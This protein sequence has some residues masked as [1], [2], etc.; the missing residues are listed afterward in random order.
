MPYSVVLTVSGGTVGEPGNPYDFD[1]SLGAIPAG[2]F[3]NEKDG[4]LSGTATVNGTFN[5]TVVATDMAGVST[6]RAFTLLVRPPVSITTTSPLPAGTIGVPYSTALVA[7]GGPLPSA[8]V[9]TFQQG[10]LPPGL[11]L[12]TAGVI[13]GT[14][15]QAGNFSALIQVQDASGAAS[16]TFD[17]FVGTPLVFDTSSPLPDGVAQGYYSEVISVSGGRG[18]YNWVLAPGSS[19]PPGLTLEAFNGSNT[20]EL[21]GVPTQEGTFVFTLRAT[22]A[23]GRQAEQQYSVT[24]GPGLQ[25]TTTSPLPPATLGSPY[26]TPFAAVGGVSP[27]YWFFGESNPPPGLDLDSD[28]VLSGTPT[29]PGVYVFTVGVGDSTENSVFREFELDVAPALTFTTESPLRD[30]VRDRSYT[31][32]ISVSGGRAPFTW[33]LAPGSTLP[34]GLSLEPPFEGTSSRLVQ[35]TPTVEGDFTFTV[36][37]TDTAGRQ[38]DRQYALRILPAMVITTTSPLPPATANVPYNATLAG[39]GGIAP[40]FWDVY[41][42][43]PP[44]LT[45]NSDTGQISGTPTQAGFYNFN[46][47]LYDSTESSVTR[48]F[49]LVVSNPL[50]ITTTSPLPDA[51]Q[52]TFYSERLVAE[53][54]RLPI[55]WTVAPGS[56][57][58]PGLSLAGE[59]AEESDQSGGEQTG[60]NGFGCCAILS[61]EPT[62]PGVYTFTLR[63][64]DADN[65]Q[66]DVPLQLTVHPPLSILTN[67]TLPPGTLDVAYNA[68]LQATGGLAPYTWFTIDGVPVAPGLTL[69]ESGVISGT[70]TQEGTYSIPIEVMDSYEN[71]AT[72]TFTIVVRPPVQITTGAQLPIGAVGSPYAAS[73]AATGGNPPYVWAVAG[74]SSLPPGIVLSASAGT[75]SGTPTQ[76]GTFQFTLRATDQDGSQDE[77]TFTLAV[78]DRLSFTTFTQLPAGTVG[79]AYSQRL[80]AAGGNAPYEFLVSPSSSLAPG[81]T[82]AAN[83]QLSGTP[84]EAGFYTFAAIV[85]DSTGTEVTGNFTLRVAG[86][87]QLLTESPLPD[88]TRTVAYAASLRATGGTLPYLFSLAPGSSLPPGLNLASRTGMLSGTPT[89]A[90]DFVFTVLLTDSIGV[91]VSRQYQLAVTTGLAITT[92]SPLPGGSEGVPYTLSF[93]AVGGTTPYEWSLV[94]GSTLPPGLSLAAGTGLLSGTPTSTGNFSFTVRVTDAQ[95]TQAILSVVLPIGQPLTIIT[96]AQLPGGQLGVAYSQ[97]IQASGGTQPYTF[98]GSP[99]S[100]P[101]GISLNGSNGV[102]SGVPSAEGNFTFPITV[103]D[104]QQVEVSRTF[105]LVITED[106]PALTILTEALPDGLLDNA[107]SAPVLVSGGMSPL[108]FSLA[109]GSLPP[110]LTGPSAAGVI[111]GTPTQAGAFTFTIRVEDSEGQFA[112]RAYTVQILGS[113]RFITGSPL[114]GGTV[115]QAVNLVLQADGGTA[116]YTFA[117]GG[118]ALPEG[119]TLNSNGTL[120]GIPTAAFNGGIPFRVTDSATPPESTERTFQWRISTPLVILT[121]ELPGGVV[122]QSYSQAILASGGTPAYAYTVS[123]GT[124]PPGLVLSGT[125]TLSGA[126]TAPSVST[127]TVRVTDQDGRTAEQVFT[128]TTSPVP[129]SNVIIE[130]NTPNPPPNSQQTVRVLLSEASEQD[131]D[132]T[133]NL[134]FTPLATPGADD[135]AIQFVTGGRAANFTVP[136]GST[137]GLFG[138]SPNSPA[139]Q[140]GTVAGEI[141]ITAALRRGGFDVTPTPPP[142]EIIVIPAVAPTISDLTVTRNATGLTVVV[143]GFSTPRN[144][145]SATLTFTPRPG[146]TT[147]GQLTFTVDLAA[148]FAAFYSQAASAQHGSR[149]QLTIPITLTGDPADITGLS[150]QLR[151]SVAAGNTLT[152]TF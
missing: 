132:G 53:G 135:P 91:E 19:L 21:G 139:I 131:L 116:P 130:P 148:A 50:L 83:G 47:I 76:A 14:P 28:G 22:D 20:R 67:A 92:T 87:L 4:T 95:G 44:G 12:S 137:G 65:R 31:E 69:S 79:T 82:L 125:G 89:L 80:A 46:V 142:T 30:A 141:R 38:A 93:T 112:E 13:S 97:P 72:R 94:N 119:I 151:N 77:R 117:L 74:E 86:L 134:A 15:N 17:I 32:S 71:I 124:V 78:I 37:V 120:S 102:L 58:P 106:A 26:S 122:G 129:V 150:V 3:L 68:T 149:F 104:A 140:T 61:G 59:P 48:D 105:V 55:N 73:L 144:M 143:R 62:T 25:I 133:L 6:S 60:S 96:G 126:P 108:T 9:W 34:A 81:L 42:D 113:L 147:S 8:Y 54:G 107:Y 27:Y 88:A 35:G 66:V 5:F 136:A 29:E 138:D 75:L 118:A 11:N 7:A 145:T 39:T 127:F 99:A 1:I 111:S 23:D 146:A 43:L 70:P 85:R 45:L 121:T 40:Y 115:G 52:D 114:P 2:H 41:P 49:T 101:P 63:V 103:R 33:A 98:V 100:L 123:A 51:V 110:G 152:A 10:A 109:A 24:F 57:L 56:T 36:R 128:V 90:G 84:T 64:V 16:R 18:P